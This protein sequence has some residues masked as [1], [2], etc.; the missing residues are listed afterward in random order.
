M[1]YRIFYEYRTSGIKFC[2]KIGNKFEKNVFI[3][4]VRYE[5]IFNLTANYTQSERPVICKKAKKYYAISIDSLKNRDFT[6]FRKL[7][8]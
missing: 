2:L 3:D 8:K 5:Y 1:N 4:I 7:T 6:T